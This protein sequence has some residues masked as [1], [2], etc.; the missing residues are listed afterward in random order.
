MSRLKAENSTRVFGMP[1]RIVREAWAQGLIRTGHSVLEVGSG[2][3]RN[4]Q[5]LLDRGASVDVVENATVANRLAQHYQSFEQKGGRVYLGEWPWRRYDAIVCTFVLGVITPVAARL[6]LLEKMQSRLS[7]CGVLALAV[8]ALGDVKTRGR[9]GVRWRD[10][11]ITP[12]GTFIKPYGKMEL[13]AFV[14]KSAFGP[15][16]DARPFRSNSGI[17]DLLLARVT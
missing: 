14:G 17:V 8:R 16:K 5:W 13:L 15:H 9:K 7:R 4:A 3:L 10:G 6:E 12:I 2:C 1:A 11:Y